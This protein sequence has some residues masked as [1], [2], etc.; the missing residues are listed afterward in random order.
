MKIHNV[1]Q[2]SEE[3]Y[4]VRSGI[5]TAS[6]FSKILSATGKPST[7]AEGYA[8]DIV[9]NILAGKP[10]ESWEGN[11][12]TERGKE[13]EQEAVDYYEFTGNVETQEVGFCIADNGLYG[14]SPDR[15]VSDDGLLEIKCPKGSVQLSYLLKG[16]LPT[17]YIPQVQGQLFVTGREWC[18]FLSYHPDLPKLQIRVKRDGSY[19]S[20]LS[21]QLT[22][23]NELVEDKKI[24]LKQLGY[25]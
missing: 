6:E 7:Q 8:N 18:D 21:A 11:Q 12:W 25:L 3:W 1:E 5:A 19:I 4:A 23:F 14:C 22:I 24:K 15:L 20:K 9:A 17:A 2:G 10:L 13:L 16:T